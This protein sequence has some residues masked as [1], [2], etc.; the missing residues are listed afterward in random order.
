MLA[1]AVLPKNYHSSFYYRMLVPFEAMAALEGVDFTGMIDDNDAST[2]MEDRV[3]MFLRSDL[4]L[5]YQPIADSLLDQIKTLKRE[6][7]EK[8]PALVIDTDDNLFRINAL[9][10][11]YRHMGIY[12]PDGNPLRVGDTVTID[13]LDGEKQVLWKDGV[14]GFNIAENWYRLTTYKEILKEADLITTS[15]QGVRNGLLREIPDIEEHCP[16]AVVP[17]M[18]IE[19]HYDRVELAE[20]PN[21]VRILWQGSETHYGDLWYMKDPLIKVV[22]KYPHVKLIFWG[23]NVPQLA[24]ALGDQYRYQGWCPY[25]EFKI[26]LATIG[27]DINL[28]PLR[29]DPFEECR[30]AIKWY[31]SSALLQPAATLAQNVGDFQR[32]IQDGVTGMLYDTSEQFEEKLSLLIEDA[33]KRKEIA[34][35]GKDWVLENRNAFRLAP[36]VFGEWEEAVKRANTRVELVA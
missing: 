11:S 1:F 26:R 32:E 9:N 36:K 24:E 3:N 35:N 2:P 19:K 23:L 15:T 16:I 28:A 14:D 29:P 13:R 33:T 7:K 4:N 8:R 17:N 27:H 10:H 34:S 20:H 30:S 25:G 21:E 22:K 18:V 31:E 5:V 6:L 12:R